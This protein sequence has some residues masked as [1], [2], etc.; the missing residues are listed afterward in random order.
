MQGVSVCARCGLERS[1][2]G[3]NRRSLRAAVLGLFSSG[4]LAKMLL[5]AVAMAAVGGVAVS[6]PSGESASTTTTQAVLQPADPVTATEA[7]VSMV[8]GTQAAD[9]VVAR[10]HAYAEAVETWGQCVA[11][12]ARDHS[13]EAF[14]LKVTCGDT[15]TA[16]D[17]GL[18]N[19]TTRGNSSTAPGQSGDTPG[20]NGEAP[21]QS[22]KPAKTDGN[23]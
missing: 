13:G 12:A 3:K 9:T 16:A 7:V 8:E 5:G 23:D 18:D 1:S 4:F 22:D 21:G 15:P 20:K 11:A 14:D 10:A 17:H 6:M 2:S 19:R